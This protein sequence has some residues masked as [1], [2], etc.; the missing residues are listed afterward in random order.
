MSLFLRHQC[1]SCFDDKTPFPGANAV[2]THHVLAGL[3]FFFFF[4]A[5]PRRN[6]T[7]KCN[8]DL[9]N[10]LFSDKT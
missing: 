4:K 7:L 3:F 8:S 6:V 9:F 5:K 2:L 10:I 1:W